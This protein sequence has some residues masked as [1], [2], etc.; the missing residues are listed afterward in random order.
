MPDLVS[1]RGLAKLMETSPIDVIKALMDNG[2]MA[3]I[4]QQLDYATAAIVAEEMGFAVEP[5]PPPQKVEIEIPKA[6]RQWIYEEEAPGDLH[7]CPPVITLLGH[8]DHGKTTL[9]DAIRRTNVVA[10]E[11]GGI[12]QR[13][14]AYQVQTDDDRAIT[15]LDTP[16]HEAFTAM[17]ARG[18][19]GADIAVLVIAA[20]DGVMPQTIEAIDHAKAAGVPILVALNKM[21][22]ANANPEM[23]K[24]QLSGVG[25]TIEEWGGNVMCV[26]VSA[27][28]KTGIKEL[29][30]SILTLADLSEIQAN[31]NRPAMGM[32]IEGKL[33]DKWGPVATLLVQNGTL[34]LRDNLVIDDI[35]GHIRAMFDYKGKRVNKAPPSMPV[36][37][38]GLSG[39][40]RAGNVFRVVKDGKVAKEMAA[41]RAEEKKRE[42]VR[43]VRA[44]TLEDIYAQLQA[45]QVKQLN[46]IL[47]ADVQGA[48][49]PVTSSLR[50]L[51]DKDLKVN[52]VH[53]GIGNITESD[54]MLAAVSKAIIIGFNVDADPA[55]RRT[56]EAEGVDIRSY[57][58]I[59]K[60]IEDVDKAL[61]GLLKPTYEAKTIGYA[62]IR[63][64]FDI[65]GKGKV[66]GVY[67]TDGQVLSSA[68]A[69]IKRNE[70]MVYDGQVASLKRFAEDVKEVKSG[71]ECGVR[72]KGFEG[73][74]EGDIIEFYNLVEA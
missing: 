52:F 46:L 50:K 19:Q 35:Y 20:D 32:V 40:P 22:K 37:A 27:K 43:P 30:A 44:F 57:K 62:E 70:E 72:L 6:P 49:E 38:L 14:G 58:I 74:K 24:K 68:M 60:L 3:N 4:N 18:A 36:V 29:L 73:F 2:V 5:E 55:A 66:A 31:P 53:Q 41:Q 69:R 17:R 23:V 12:T 28:E 45:G 16:G 56:A 63:A 59:Y 25:L 67:V 61:K 71:Y 8:V 51:G 47:K 42:A 10:G 54:A 39:V 34:K 7:P 65:P 11:A 64:I 9:L 26:P 15:F 13:I 33:D 1:V 21:D 48:L